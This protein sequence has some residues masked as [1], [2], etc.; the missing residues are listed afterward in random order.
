MKLF[1][2]REHWWVPLLVAAAI[3]LV[4]LVVQVARSAP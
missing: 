2:W 3:I 4:F 1:N